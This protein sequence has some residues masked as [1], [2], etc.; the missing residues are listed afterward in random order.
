[1][2]QH[3]RVALHRAAD[4][5]DHHERPRLRQCVRV[6]ARERLAA[7]A[8]VPARRPLQIE[9]RVR[10]LA[11]SA[12]SSAC[13]RSHLSVAI[14]ACAWS[15]SSSVN[16]AKSLTARHLARA[17]A[18]RRDLRVVVSRR[19]GSAASRPGSGCDAGISTCGASGAVAVRPIARRSFGDRCRRQ[20]PE[21]AEHLVE[22]RQILLAMNQQR[23]SAA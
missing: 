2:E 23:W 17:V 11:S 12:A 6:W 5:A 8:E 21:D 19:V 22:D 14:I 20:P 15:S 9:R 4:V 7:V 1:M 10:L 13:P 3:P 16:S 18:G